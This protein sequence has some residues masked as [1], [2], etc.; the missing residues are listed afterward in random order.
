MLRALREGKIADAGVKI[1]AETASSCQHRN[2]L[3]KI[4]LWRFPE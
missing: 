1:D 2:E 4:R 3:I